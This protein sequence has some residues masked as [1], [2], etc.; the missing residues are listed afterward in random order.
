MPANCRSSCGHDLFVIQA[1]NFCCSTL[2]ETAL[3][4]P[5]PV[6]TGVGG[7]L[8]RF[9]QLARNNKQLST[10]ATMRIFFT[11]HSFQNSLAQRIVPATSRDLSSAHC[12]PHDRNP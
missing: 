12:S 7:F 2:S 8:T 5:L 6:A 10:A 4:S 9:L 3:I 1:F 11:I